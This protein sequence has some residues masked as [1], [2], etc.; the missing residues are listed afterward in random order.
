MKNPL[1]YRLILVA[2]SLSLSITLLTSA[3]Y[4]ITNHF[5]GSGN[6]KISASD[7]SIQAGLKIT[8]IANEGFLL[9]SPS[10]KVLI[11]A[12]YKNVY[13]PNV[14]P[15]A[16]LIQKMENAD[17]PFDNIDII[18]IT[19][20]HNDHYDINCVGKHLEKDIKAILVCPN[21]VANAFRNYS[22]YNAIKERIISI[23]AGSGV[24]VDTIFNDVP[25]TIFGFRHCLS[26]F[27]DMEHNSYLLNMEGV[28]IYH[29]GD[30]WGYKNE[31][32]AFN[33]QNDSIDVGFFEVDMFWEAVAHNPLNGLQRINQYFSPDNIVLMHNNP[34]YLSGGEQIVNNVKNVF[35]NIYLFKREMEEKELKN[36]IL[37][38]DREINDTRTIENFRL[39]Q[40]YPNPFNPSTVINYR[41]TE[42]DNVELKIYDALGREIKTLVDSYQNAGDHSIVWDGTSNSN[43]S[44]CSG[45]YIY[46]LKTGT[47]KLLKKM[48]LVQ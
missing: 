10:K 30:S 1:T 46:C 34:T 22:N 6:N 17:P 41:L 3:Q 9:N 15:S 14:K 20:D 48:I 43:S 44:V 42:S 11:D 18:C 27:Y 31:F 28:K 39:N 23:T 33:L 47:T 26:N 19:H 40:N 35:P 24:K 45:M 8:F 37:T 5:S 12:L 21:S 16:Q 38:S 29:S 2:L 36:S 7:G 25:I 32:N 4:G 13:S